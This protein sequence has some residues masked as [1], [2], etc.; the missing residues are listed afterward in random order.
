[1]RQLADGRIYTGR[2]AKELGLV[3][4]LGN[5]NYAVN[6]AGK[7]AGIKGRP[8]LRE[9]GATNPLSMLLGSTTMGINWPAQLL[10]EGPA[11]LLKQWPASQLPLT[12][13]LPGEGG[14]ISR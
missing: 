2:Q 11:Q 12:S 13:S 9:F 1:V 14:G 4:D 3:D 10:K 8:A 5:F 6:Y 7:L